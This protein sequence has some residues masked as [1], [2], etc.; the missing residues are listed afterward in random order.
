ML[1]RPQLFRAQHR[2]RAHCV[3]MTAPQSGP[4]SADAAG[5]HAREPSDRAVREQLQLPTG[6]LGASH[7][8]RGAAGLGVDDYVYLAGNPL[9]CATQAREV[10]ALREHDARISWDCR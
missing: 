7:Q 2:D 1:V 3:G 9:D 8:R 6:P 4:G 10:A 5:E